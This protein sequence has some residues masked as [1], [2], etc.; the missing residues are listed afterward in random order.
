MN[1]N[2]EIEKTLSSLDEMDTINVKPFFYT[3]LAARMERNVSLSFKQKGISWAMLT[4]LLIINI[5]VYLSF[6]GENSTADETQQLTELKEQYYPE[7]ESY[8]ALIEEYETE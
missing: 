6:S 8:Y 3:R 4:A 7:S 1:R 2:E 5:G